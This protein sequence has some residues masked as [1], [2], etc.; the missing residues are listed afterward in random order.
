MPAAFHMASV[1]TVGPDVQTTRRPDDDLRVVL[2]QW[3]HPSTAN[4]PRFSSPTLSTTLGGHIVAWVSAG[5][6]G[7]YSLDGR[8]FVSGAPGSS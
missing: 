1:T 5:G 7:S 2:G 3:R 8:R 4:N 6:N